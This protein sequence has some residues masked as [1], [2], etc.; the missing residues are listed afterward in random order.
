MM[1]SVLYCA[2]IYNLM[3]QRQMR[4][5]DSRTPGGNVQTITVA[6]TSNSADRKRGCCN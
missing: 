4:D 6:P 3:P 5:D 1:L 2:E